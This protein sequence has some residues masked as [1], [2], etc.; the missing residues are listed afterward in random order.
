[1]KL[2]ESVAAKLGFDPTGAE[3][4]DGQVRSGGRPRAARR[5]RPLRGAD[6]EDA[7]EYGDLAKRYQQSTFA[8]HFV[9]VGVDAYTGENAGAAHA[10]GLRSRPNPQP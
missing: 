1:M 8:A 9:E 3:F 5:R 6:G 4:A 10:G 7:I 2:R